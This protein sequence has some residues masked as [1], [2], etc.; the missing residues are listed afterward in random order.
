MLIMIT[1]K[2]SASQTLN[3]Y[4]LQS[5]NL[6]AT[7][8]YLRHFKEILHFQKKENDSNIK[9]IKCYDCDIKEH[10]A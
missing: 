6:N 4:K 1:Y 3:L 10:Y 9:K 5:I 8:R 7:Y 2:K